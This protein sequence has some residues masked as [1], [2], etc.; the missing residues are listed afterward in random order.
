MDWFFPKNDGGQFHG[1][2]D[3]GIDLFKG[4]PVKSLTRE[5]CQNSIDAGTSEEPVK[6]QFDLFRMDSHNI[7]GYQNLKYFYDKANTFCKKQRKRN[8]LKVLMMSG[9]KPIT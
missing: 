2:G 7:P 3:S 6:I 1:I 9:R 5:I 4:E 8:M